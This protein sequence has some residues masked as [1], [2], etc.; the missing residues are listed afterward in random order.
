[1]FSAAEGARDWEKFADQIEPDMKA[2]ARYQDLLLV[3]QEI[4]GKTRSLP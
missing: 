3:F 4:S 1:L 2:H